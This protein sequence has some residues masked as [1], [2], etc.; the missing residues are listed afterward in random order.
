[1]HAVTLRVILFIFVAAI[2]PVYEK[3][4]LDLLTDLDTYIGK[5]Q[6]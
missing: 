2:D 1:M 3:T 5:E 4:P 6:K